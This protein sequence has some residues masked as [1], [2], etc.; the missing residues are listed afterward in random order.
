MFGP[1]S[2]RFKPRQAVTSDRTRSASVGPTGATHEPTWI[3]ST[4]AAWRRGEVVG[5]D[6]TA[7]ENHDPAGCVADQRGEEVDAP[8]CGRRAAGGQDA[9]DA[10]RD[11][12]IERREW[13]ADGVEGF[14]ERD[15][16]RPGEVDERG[17]A[18]DVQGGVG[19]QQTQD[20]TGCALRL[21][22][23]D[24]RVHQSELRVGV[25]EITGA[26]SNENVNGNAHPCARGCRFGNGGSDAADGAVD[27]Q[28]DPIRA[29]VFGGDGRCRRLHA[30][31]DRGGQRGGP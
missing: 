24:L 26:W 14:V 21:N 22:F 25:D 12:R 29:S 15:G 4:P 5:N 11:Q 30:D 17:G 10:E 31:L 7:R 19:M 16:E 8:A 6:R 23:K 2:S 13:V 9:V 27:A 1:Q 20:D 3:S 28:L 18:R